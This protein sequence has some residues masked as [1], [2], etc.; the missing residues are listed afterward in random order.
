MAYVVPVFR[1]MIASPGDT[2]EIR[3]WLYERMLNFNFMDSENYRFA[4]QPILW[5][6]HAPA[7]SGKDPQTVLDEVLV[8]KADILIAIFKDEFGNP[9]AGHP[10]GT[11]HEIETFSNPDGGQHP[12][13]IFKKNPV[14]EDEEVLEKLADYKATARSRGYLTADYEHDG[15]A[16]DKAMNSIIYQAQTLLSV[17]EAM[18]NEPKGVTEEEPAETP[19]PPTVPSGS[20]TASSKVS[21]SAT[22][23]ALTPLDA[24]ARDLAK[25]WSNGL[26]FPVSEQAQ[27]SLNQLHELATRDLVASMNESNKKALEFVA[28]QIAATV[29]P[30]GDE[31]A[32]N[33][34][35]VAQAS[36]RKNRE[37][38]D[39]GDESRTQEDPPGNT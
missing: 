21:S 3:R 36:A 26:R 30:S 4:L 24:A 22:G 11:V 19:E 7:A 39:E 38:T 17:L 23:E 5:E 37:V 20:A 27:E 32:K 35:R 31:L 2:S 1:T 33:W 14:N 28:E 9:V 18:G 15:D 10:S 34:G 16:V 12:A 25:R 29:R 8:S 6:K 13:V